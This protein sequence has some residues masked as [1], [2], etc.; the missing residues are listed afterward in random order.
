MHRWTLAYPKKYY[1]N[2]NFFIFAKI[3]LVSFTLAAC[4]S[5]VVHSFNIIDVNS[6]VCWDRILILV[7][8]TS[9]STADSHGSAH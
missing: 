4:E 6:S 8:A 9:A 7:T 3:L 5:P 1:N 2:I